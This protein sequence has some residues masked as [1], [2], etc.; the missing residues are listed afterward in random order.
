MT[1]SLYLIQSK[2]PYLMTHITSQILAVIS[3][4]NF[5]YRQHHLELE[6]RATHHH[7]H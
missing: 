6:K 3:N 7:A 5:K 1:N 2:M 4:L